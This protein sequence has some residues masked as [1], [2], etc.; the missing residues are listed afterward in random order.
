VTHVQESR[1]L[2]KQGFGEKGK[3][4][5]SKCKVQKKVKIVTEALD[6]WLVQKV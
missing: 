6:T 5:E 1:E 3:V 2:C 4:V